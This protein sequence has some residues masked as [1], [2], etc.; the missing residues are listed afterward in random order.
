MKTLTKRSA[1]R[2]TMLIALAG[3]AWVA[4]DAWAR[5]GSGCYVCAYTIVFGGGGQ[6]ECYEIP[7]NMTGAEGWTKCQGPGPDNC[8]WGEGAAECVLVE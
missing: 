3:A 4:Q 2:T 8:Q 6:Y 5:E 7:E 1:I